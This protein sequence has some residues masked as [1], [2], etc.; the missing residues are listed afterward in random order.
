MVE[1]DAIL[2]ARGDDPFGKT[3]SSR[4]RRASRP[5][6]D[7]LNGAQQTQTTD[8]PNGRVIAERFLQGC[9]QQ[10]ALV[11][12]GC[13]QVAILEDLE[14]CVPSRRA[15]DVVRVGEAVRE[16]GDLLVDFTTASSEPKRPIAGRCTLR[17]NQD[18]RPH[19]PMLTG[20]PLAGPP[21]PGHHL[22]SNHQYAVLPADR[23]NR[24]PVVVRRDTCA[25]CRTGD[26]L[27]DECRNSLGAL[28]NYQP[29]QMIRV[30]LPT[31]RGSVFIGRRGV[32]GRSQ[33]GK[34]RRLQSSPARDVQRATSIAVV[35]ALAT[36]HH[37]PVLTTR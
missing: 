24:G 1:Q 16:P 18:V 13:D 31:E 12:R 6:G 28:S 11:L 35:R 17:G 23:R 10:G 34:V 5:V 26:R 27:G 25:K 22:V 3:V 37:R 20:E 32:H 30:L 8:V 19:T 33:P 7:E 9:L 21:E 2:L 14:Y 15:D 4:V 36:D 29:L